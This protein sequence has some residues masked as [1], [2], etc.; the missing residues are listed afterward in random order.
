[1]PKV[2]ENRP[3]FAELQKL[4][5]PPIKNANNQKKG[6]NNIASKSH[7]VT[8]P[9]FEIEYDLV[10]L[11]D[12][13]TPS[14]SSSTTV[15]ASFPK[16]SSKMKPN[17]S[18]HSEANS[19]PNSRPESSFSKGNKQSNAKDDNPNVQDN[20]KEASNA[21]DSKGRSAP[22][23]PAL[24]PSEVVLDLPTGLSERVLSGQQ[25][26]IELNGALYLKLD[27]KKVDSQW[28]KKVREDF[29]KSSSRTESQ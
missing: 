5:A 7:S 3:S 23:A 13:P 4:K 14:A 8:A 17:G 29:E 9:L 1:V 10:G 19:P 2:E 28:L 12:A 27:P 26:L 22:K 6:G 25:T 18:D 16:S 15:A 24:K 20:K 21:N 11:G